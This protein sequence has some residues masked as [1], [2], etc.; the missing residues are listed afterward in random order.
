M[1]ASYFEQGKVLLPRT[2]HLPSVDDLIEELVG[3]GSRAHDDRVDAMS[4]VAL[5]WAQR[6]PTVKRVNQSKESV[7]QLLHRL[8]GPYKHLTNK[9]LR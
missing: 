9:W 7:A 3:F 2:Q 8:N 5:R 4:M 1:L 6:V